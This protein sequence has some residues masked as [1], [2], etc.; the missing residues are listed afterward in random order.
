MAVVMFP[1]WKIIKKSAFWGEYDKGYYGNFLS[2]EVLC[3]I[4]IY[5]VHLSPLMRNH[6]RFEV[7]FFLFFL[8]I[9]IIVFIL[10]KALQKISWNILW[11]INIVIYSIK[12]I[13]FLISDP[14]TKKFSETFLIETSPRSIIC[15]SISLW[16]TVGDFFFDWVK[17]LRLLNLFLAAF[18]QIACSTSISSHYFSWELVFKF[19]IEISI[20]IKELPCWL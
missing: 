14:S 20:S 19:N 6:L 3:S 11:S 4:S 9:I 5:F 2:C 8:L 12:I 7:H 18:V 13:L 17:L 10:I 1:F 15:S 16:M